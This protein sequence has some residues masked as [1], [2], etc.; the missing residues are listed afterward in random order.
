[1]LVDVVDTCESF[2]L[3]EFLELAGAT[4]SRYHF[5]QHAGPG[6]IP[7]I[8]T[9]DHGPELF[10]IHMEEG[11]YVS[12]LQL[13][14]ISNYVGLSLEECLLV[15]SMLGLTNWRTLVQNPL[16]VDVDL[17]HEAKATCLFAPRDTKPEFAILFESLRLCPGCAQ[18]YHFLSL[19]SELLALRDVLAY[20]KMTAG[21][22]TAD[23]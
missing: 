13:E 19:E 4:Q 16:M 5:V 1:M 14:G 18:F 8:I 9:Q 15:C 10:R 3:L 23:S 20:A 12:T 11:V 21:S 6:A 2:D 7:L 22:L 17:Y